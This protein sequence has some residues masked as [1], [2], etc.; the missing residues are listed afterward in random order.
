M[1]HTDLNDLIYR[2]R[3]GNPQAAGEL[4]ELYHQQI[5][6]YL[7]YRTGD[8]LAAEDLT[9]EVFIKMIK[10]LPRFQPTAA[11]F[12]SWLF[13]IAHN[14]AVDHLRWQTSHP[15]VRLDDD[16]PA[17]DNPAAALEDRLSSEQ[18]RGALQQLSGD[19]RD[20]L[21]LRFIHG[22]SLADTASALRRSPDAVKGLQRRALQ[23]LRECLK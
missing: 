17:A 13:Q 7:G 6:R 1:P 11:S 18:L 15:A 14:A 5:F 19:Q 3:N 21:L 8:W 23:R 16:Q 12:A 10:A 20:V 22:L 2:A 4:Y 9:G